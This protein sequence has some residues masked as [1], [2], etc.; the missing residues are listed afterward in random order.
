MLKLTRFEKLQK[1][2]LAKSF[3]PLLDELTTCDEQ[4]FLIKLKNIQEWDRPKD[5]LFIWIPVL[6][7]IDDFLSKIIKKYS[8]ESD[9]Y[10][11]RPVKLNEMSKE[12]EDACVILT[13]FTSRLLFNT[14]KRFIY[15]STDVMNNL[16]NCPNFRV[17]LGAIKVLAIV[18]ERYLISRE[19]MAPENA[20][21]RQDLKKKVLKLALAFPSSVPDDNGEHFTIAD[22]FFDKKNIPSKWTKLKYA[23]FSSEK[24]PHNRDGNQQSSSMKKFCLSNEDLRTFSL[25]QLFDKGMEVLPSETWF[26]YSLQVTLAKAFSD[27][28]YENLQLRNLIIR[29]KF[30]SVAL[31]NT[32]YVPPQVSSKLFEI[33]PYTFNCLTDFISLAEQKIPSALRLDALFALECISLKHVWCSDI[34]RNLGGNLSHGALFQILRQI[35]KL[36]RTEDGEINEEYNVRFFYVIVNISAVKTL[37]DSL[38]AAGLIPCLLNIISIKQTKYRRTTASATHLLQS[39]IR[40]SSS[41]TE[42][43]ANDGFNILINCITEEITFALQNPDFAKPPKYGPTDYSISFRQQAYIRSLLKLTIRL[44]KNDSGDRIRNLIDSPI[45][46]SLKQILENRPVFGYT[47]IEYTLDVVQKVINSEPT[48]YSILVEAGLVPFIIDHFEE[49]I[50]PHPHLI[51][52]LPDVISALCLSNSGLQRVKE[53]NMVKYLFDAIMNPEFSRALSWT[54]ELNDFGSSIDELARHYPDLQPLILDAFC[55]VVKELPNKINYTQSFLYEPTGDNDYFYHSKDEP[56]LDEEESA[57]ELAFWDIQ[58]ST[59]ILDCFTSLFYGMTLDSSVLHALPEVLRVEDLLS[60]VNIDR[61]PFDFISSQTMLNIVDILQTFEEEHKE[62]AFTAV[63][64]V[65]DKKL[66]NITEFLRFHN[67][68]SFFL[69]ARRGQD[70]SGIDYILGELSGICSLLYITSNVYVHYSRLTPTRVTQILEYFKSEGFEIIENL[71]LLLQKC[72]LEEMYI[73][74]NLPDQVATETRP[75]SYGHAPPILIHSQ[76]PVRGDQKDNKTSAKFKNTFQTRRILSNIQSHIAILFKAFL[77]LS[78][79]KDRGNTELQLDM[80]NQ[81]MEVR[82]FDVVVTHLTKMI[83]EIPR[84]LNPG[85][86]LVLLN[87]N[88]YVL[89]FPK[90]GLS[91]GDILQTVPAVLFYQKGGYNVYLELVTEWLSKLKDFKDLS[92]VEEIDYVKDTKEVLIVS[93]IIN[94]LSFFNKSIRTDTV[95]TIK[96]IEDYYS[97][98]IFSKNLSQGLIERIQTLSLF[99]LHTWNDSHEIFSSNNRTIPYTVFKQLLT[100]MNNSYISVSD[101]GFDIELMHEL[102]WDSIE[103]VSEQ[104]RI[105]TDAGVDSNSA[106][107][108]LFGLSI[109]KC[110]DSEIGEQY[111]DELVDARTSEQCEKILAANNQALNILKIYPDKELR[112][113]SLNKLR[114]QM[115]DITV[116]KGGFFEVLPLYPKLVNAITKTSLEMMKCVSEPFVVI[117]HSIVQKIETISIDD[118]STLSSHLHMFGILLSER[119]PSRVDKLVMNKFM[120]H[121]NNILAPEHVNTAWFSKAL[122]CYE[123]LLSASEL[124]QLEPLERNLKIEAEMPVEP[125]DVYPVSAKTKQTMFHKLI[126]VGDISNFYSAVS[127]CRILLLYARDPLNV[128][129]VNQSGILSK[130]LKVIGQ[131]QKSDKIRFLESAFLLLVRRCFEDQFVV[132]NLIRFELQKSFVTRSLGEPKEKIRELRDILDEKPHTVV[133]NPTIFTSVLCESAQFIDFSDKEYLSDL[134]LERKKFKEGEDIAQK[135]TR[136]KTEFQERSGIV[137]LLLTQLMAAA[138]KDWLSEPQSSEYDDASKKEKQDKPE[139]SRNPVCAYMIFLLKVLIELVTSYDQCKLEFLTFDKRNIYSERPKPRAAALNFFLYQILDKS[140]DVERTKHELKRKEVISMLAKSVVVGFMTSVQDASITKADPK[141]A[142]PDITFIRKFTVE[143]I[144]KALKYSTS[145]QKLLEANVDKIDTWLSTLSL[146]VYIQAPY[147]RLLLDPNRIDADRYQICKIMLEL[148]IPSTI[149]DCMANLDLNYPFCKRLFN[150]AVDVLNAITS[151]RN[152]FSDLFKIEV[153]DDDVEVEE[154]SEKEEASDMFR[155]SALGMYDVEDV[156]DDDDDDDGDSLIVDDEDIAFVDTDEDGFEVVFTDENEDDDEEEGGVVDGEREEASLLDSDEAAEYS[157]SVDSDGMSVEID[158]IDTDESD[159]QVFVESDSYSGDG[160]E[161]DYSSDSMIEISDYDDVDESDWE[162]GLSDLSSSEDDNDDVEDTEADMQETNRF[163]GARRIWTLTDG[164]EL[165]DESSDEETRGVFQGIEHVFSP[166]E[167][168]LFRVDDAQRQVPRHRHRSSRGG[169]LL[170]PSLSFLNNGRRNQSNLV[171]PLGPSG[172]EQIESD[173][174]DQLVSIGTGARPRSNRTHFA[175][176]LFSGEIFDEKTISGVVLKST[177]ARW[178]DVY[179]MFYDSRSDLY[180]II[181]SI[182]YRLFQPSLEA[183]RKTKAYEE[184]LFQRSHKGEFESKPHDFESYPEDADVSEDEDSSGHEDEDLVLEDPSYE[185]HIDGATSPEAHEHEPVYVNI[186]GEEVD[187]GGTDIDPEFL[188]ALPDEMRSEVFAQHVRERRAEAIHNEGIHTREIDTEFLS[189]IPQTLREEILEQEAAETRFS[190]MINSIRSNVTQNE[191]YDML[192]DNEEDNSAAIN[193][194]DRDG[195]QRDQPITNEAEKKKSGRIY[196]EPLLDR[197]GISALV[198]AIFISQPYIQREIYHE[199]FYRLCSSKQDR[200]DIINLL[201]FILTEGTINQHSLEKVYTLISSRAQGSGKFSNTRQVSADCTPLVV[202]NQTIEI[203]QN[204]IDTDARLKFFFITEHENLMVNKTILKNKKDIFNRNEKLPIKYL[205]SLLTRK[206]ITD[207]T[208][209]MDLLTN[210]L[211]TCTKAISV[212]AKSLNQASSKKIKMQL[213]HLEL[214]ELKLIISIM[215]LDSC[216]TKVFQQSLNIMYNLS[217]LKGSIEIFTEELIA[218]AKTTS[219]LLTN[220]LEAFC[221]EASKVGNGTEMDAE[222]VQKITVPSSEQAKLLKVLTAMDYLYTHKKKD[223]Q[224][225]LETLSSLYNRM[226]LGTVWSALSMCLTTFEKKKNLNTS[227]TILLPSIEALMVVCKHSKINQSEKPMKYEERNSDFS[228]I[229]VENL[230]FPF[231][232]THKKLLNQMVRSNPK[233]MSGP[234]SLLVKN[235][236]IL[237]FDNKRYYFNAKLRS[238]LRDRPKLPISV[239]RNQVFL[240]SYRALFFKADDEIKKSKLEITFKGESGVDAGGVT[241][242]WYQV[243][244]RQMFNPDY[245]L[246]LPVASDKTTFHPNRASGINP[247]HLSFFK[248]IGMIIGK[249]ICDQCFLDCHFSREVYKNI[250]GKPVSLKDMESLDLDYY[251]S[252]VWILENDITDIFEETFSVEVDDYGE[253]KIVDLIE[254]GRNIPVSEANKREYVKSIV[255]YKLHLSVKE[256]MDNFLTGFYT[257]IPKDIIS[258]FDEQELELLISG[259]PDIDVDDWR[260]NTTYVNYTESCKQVNYFWRAVRSF[261]AEERAKLLQFITGTSKVPLNGFKELSGVSGVCK[262]SIHRDYGSTERLPSSHTCFNQLNLPAYSSYETLR[263]SLLIAINEGSE[264]FGLA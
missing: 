130:I 192:S 211:E 246:F 148:N 138:Q 95:E 168:T 150:N 35:G 237:D 52:L 45:L 72:V 122:Y 248:F 217:T 141:I 126:R 66:R 140:S 244:S 232:D 257:L 131:C 26:D 169:G 241:R 111:A 238:E 102:R 8:Y 121:M 39:F 33:D 107:R 40:D 128:K 219:K 183:F 225:N 251:K 203:L 136:P 20:L 16:L 152:D 260:N 113:K 81:V 60:T 258:I 263:G 56:I 108:F 264:G 58:D 173:L 165:E 47:L 123:I 24:K 54:E 93:C 228:Q 182:V 109:S 161:E 112:S 4:S 9:N 15:A 61:P 10:K 167:E 175:D 48:I 191:D 3:Q 43:I 46:A 13:E 155:N 2:Y 229:S 63:F 255:E 99:M 205:F 89:S 231:T 133:R 12:N 235:P 119:P 243:L 240:D 156:E 132:E 29:T 135:K 259:L 96:R 224:S 207:E 76:K 209:L 127:I 18:G 27:D 120:N 14:E 90:A 105:L 163:R 181:P 142:D 11:K 55:D 194:N 74:T 158:V 85:Y 171:N 253:H 196:F 234:F 230:F 100:I 67:N 32:I 245:A 21:T 115:F 176:V 208:V 214:K 139:P 218:Q 49:F 84:N 195:D 144:V 77:R 215:N 50:A 82:T 25:Q 51:F 110:K 213:P 71:S 91:S 239:N 216:T 42:F 151:T 80:P 189:A 186:D 68:N 210:I 34:M 103:A 201:L 159:S 172:L 65:L 190:H 92:G 202:A 62:Y 87:F 149:T 262:F 227:A 75:E 41:T 78:H 137:H 145:T 28:S 37:H 247:E 114:A 180:C 101:E 83:K 69:S 256:Q 86:F 179:D 30:N 125:L 178:K 226:G 116:R 94:V 146:M 31:V 70:N 117:Q 222:L 254:N 197:T 204:L 233:L 199:L 221:K 162:S 249:A 166:E 36:L 157:F 134:V 73:R 64:G 160:D 59:G 17:K 104:M 7:R 198:K 174:N 143:A 79:S 250:L 118:R 164:I 184:S 193:S 220:D 88:S 44:L 223:E 200:S 57:G 1:E 236:K 147:L 261:D 252:L 185:E 188:N 98:V 53:K 212:V 23:Y 22:L 19:R 38:L 106:R 206:L 6:N 5:D 153:N 177:I 129:D 242:E 97:N 154:E 170:P 187:I 124:P